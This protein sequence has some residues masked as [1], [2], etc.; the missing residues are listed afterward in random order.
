[1][2]FVETHLGTTTGGT[3]ER[4]QSE[5][6]RQCFIDILQGNWRAH[7]PYN[8]TTR[9]HA[10]VDMYDR[11]NQASVFRTFQGW[12]ALSETGPSQGTIRFFP[13]VLLSNAYIILRPFFRMKA[14]ANDPLPAENWE[15]G[16]WINLTFLSDSNLIVL[17]IS[18][19]QTS[20]VLYL[21]EM[22][23]RDH[24]LLLSS[25]LTSSSSVP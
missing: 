18:T 3:I 20:Q 19:H 6:F 5:S 23:T 7:D 11:P 2:I 17:Q 15:L 25:I 9:V 21:R 16:S 13:D 22:A 12:L 4:W 24:N 10:K 1:M 8:L 14:G